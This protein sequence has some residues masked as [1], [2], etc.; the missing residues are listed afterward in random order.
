MM[1]PSIRAL[2][3][4]ETDQF[5]GLGD[6]I[7]RITVNAENHLSSIARDDGTES[8]NLRDADAKSEGRFSHTSFGLVRTGTRSQWLVAMGLIFRSCLM[9]R[10]VSSLPKIGN[11]FAE[12]LSIKFK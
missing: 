1:D 9:V 5:H 3:A 8:R 7:S 10:N 2:G 12:C 6:A 4:P 11:Q